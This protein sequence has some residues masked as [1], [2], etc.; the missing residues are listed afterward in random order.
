MRPLQPRKNIRKPS[1]NPHKNAKTL[2][3]GPRQRELI[4]LKGQLCR[5]LAAHE[6][7]PGIDIPAMSETIHG[8][9]LET[10]PDT[11]Q[12]GERIRQSPAV[13]QVGVN[14]GH[15]AIVEAAFETNLETGDVRAWRA[16]FAK[17]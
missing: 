12:R 4:V 10:I 17:A 14:Q 15:V 1:A 7:Q 16:T 5:K 2:I 3:V 8:V 6:L 11:G 13:V 9:V